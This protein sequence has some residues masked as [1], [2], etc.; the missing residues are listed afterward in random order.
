MFSVGEVAS[1]LQVTR[2]A[3]YKQAS[4]LQA[5]G[6]MVKDKFDKWKINEQGFNYLKEK[7]TAHFIIEPKQ[8]A[9]PSKDYITELTELYKEKIDTLNKQ[10]EKEIQ[11]K[12]YFKLKFEERDKQYTE[13]INQKL[14]SGETAKSWWKFWK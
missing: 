14:L 6:F 12:E 3:I 5:K 9:E 11:D 4:E 7:R 13:L 8:E 2:Q 1:Q 10:L